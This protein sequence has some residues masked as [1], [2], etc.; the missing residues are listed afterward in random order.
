MEFLVI[1]LNELPSWLY[2]QV[3]IY[4]F[5]TKCQINQAPLSYMACSSSTCLFL[6]PMMFLVAILIFFLRI[7][8]GFA[9]SSY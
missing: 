7:E 4:L 2:P 1:V 5:E 6:A 3:F 9:G 8:A